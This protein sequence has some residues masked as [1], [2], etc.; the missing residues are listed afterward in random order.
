MSVGDE[1]S[2]VT[3]ILLSHSSIGAVFTFCVQEYSEHHKT[4]LPSQLDFGAQAPTH[5]HTH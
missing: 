3:V 1:N 5:T 2:K 4:H